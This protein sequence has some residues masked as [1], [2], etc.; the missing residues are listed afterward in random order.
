M[1][2]LNKYSF[3]TI[4]ICFFIS[5][6]CTLS[7]TLTAVASSG[8]TNPATW[9]TGTI[10]VDGDVVII[11]V[12]FIVDVSGVNGTVYANITITVNGEL[13]LN[14]GQKLR[15]DC[16]SSASIS[17]GGKLSGDNGG[18]KLVV[19]GADAYTGPSL[20]S[21]PASFGLSTLPI[22][23]INFSAEIKNNSE[24]E[25]KWQTATESNNDFFT[26]ERSENGAIYSELS[27][28]D[29][30][31]NSSTTLSYSFS[32]KKPIEGTSYYRLKQTDFD[33]KYNYSSVLAV[34]FEKI[35]SG[36][37]LTVYP[38]PCSSECNV[39]LVDCDDNERPDINV[40]LIDASGNKVYSKVPV[41]DEK[42]SFS[43]TLDTKNNLKPG[44]YIVRGV[45]RKENYSKKILVK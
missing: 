26:I 37:V 36:C 30:A 44:V 38:N 5:I 29:G 24:L 8:W 22:E 6:K 34:N 12:G 25:L 7:A 10:P 28:V 40:E 21:G 31:G 23:L 17:A 14:N 32:D 41:R 13:N 45:S 27:I 15:I 43:F 3:I 33:G 16:S 39:D 9:S 2:L 19:C 42:G 35:A 1:K 4:C 18:S 11:P 20:L